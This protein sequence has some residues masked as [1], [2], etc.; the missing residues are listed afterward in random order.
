VPRQNAK[1]AGKTRSKEKRALQILESAWGACCER[2]KARSAESQQA[3]HV[4]YSEQKPHT[5]KRQPKTQ[6][7]I[8]NLQHKFMASQLTKPTF[9][10]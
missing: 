7:Q 2:H 3:P 6:R 4:L 1:Q 10:Q 5:H 9:P 8:T